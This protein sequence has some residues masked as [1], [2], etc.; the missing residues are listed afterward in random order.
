MILHETASAQPAETGATT[1]ALCFYKLKDFYDDKDDRLAPITG[2]RAGGSVT[3]YELHQLERTQINPAGPSRPFAAS[4][5][6]YQDVHV[7]S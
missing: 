3:T 7:L 1:T 5:V 2:S 6:S 4:L